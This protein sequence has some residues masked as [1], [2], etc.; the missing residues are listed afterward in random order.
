MWQEYGLAWSDALRVVISAITLYVAVL[1]V[2][3]VLGQRTLASMS[4]FDLA[5]VIALGAV[6]GR[7]ILGNTPTL[8]AGLLGLVTLLTLQAVAGQVR[9]LGRG[10]QLVNSRPVLLMA[11]QDMLRDNLVRSHVV[12]E[13]VRAKLRLAGIRHPSEV[14]C[15]VLESTGQISVLRR[16]QPID[17]ALLEGV[18]GADRMPQDLLWGGGRGI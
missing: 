9:R 4:S 13:E 17:P 7:A 12:E 8:V 3:R 11:G 5:A 1:L 10:A 16:G 14:A 18:A 15:V 6:I 2:I